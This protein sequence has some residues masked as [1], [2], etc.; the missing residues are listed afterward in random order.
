M[1]EN[2]IL[3]VTVVFFL[4]TYCPM[5]CGLP[6]EFPVHAPKAVSFMLTFKGFIP[7]KFTYSV[8]CLSGLSITD[9]LGLI[10]LVC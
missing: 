6:R 5:R 3:D 10:N 2:G 7:R 4:D 1:V 8:F 9:L